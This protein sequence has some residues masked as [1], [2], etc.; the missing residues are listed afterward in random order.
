MIPEGLCAC[1]VADSL[2]DGVCTAAHFVM[3]GMLSID[4]EEQIYE[5]QLLQKS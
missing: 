1:Y 3:D 5:A 2:D 4:G